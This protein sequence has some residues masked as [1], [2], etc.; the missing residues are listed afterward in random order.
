MSNYLQEVEACVQINEQ[1]YRDLCAENRQLKR[2]ARLLARAVKFFGA[3]L[4]V[5]R[6]QDAADRVLAGSRNHRL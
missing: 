2:D 4:F 1:K 3:R 5:K 6:I